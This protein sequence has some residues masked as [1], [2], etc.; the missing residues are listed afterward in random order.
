MDIRRRRFQR[1]L[2]R[3]IYYCD[4]VVF[5]GIGYRTK[6]GILSVLNDWNGKVIENVQKE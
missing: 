5:I 6:D 4:G 3:E 1:N 2:E